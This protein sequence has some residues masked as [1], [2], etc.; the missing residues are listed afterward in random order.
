[1]TENNKYTYECACVRVCVC[2]CVCVCVL[3]LCVWRP[4]DNLGF[5][6]SEGKDQGLKA[7]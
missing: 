5:H 1:M 4:E 3:C 6:S 7:G 2:V